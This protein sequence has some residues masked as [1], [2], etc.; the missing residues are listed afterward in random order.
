MDYLL[1]AP[2]PQLTCISFYSGWLRINLSGD[3]VFCLWAGRNFTGISYLCCL[4]P[5]KEL[6][7]SSFCF[8]LGRKDWKSFYFTSLYLFDLFSQLAYVLFG[9]LGGPLLGL[10]TFGM[11]CP[12]GNKWVLRFFYEYHF[13]SLLQRACEKNLMH[14]KLKRR[15]STIE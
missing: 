4:C 8:V 10:F 13:F 7:A 9:I 1:T 5:N 14:V 6:T 3:G 12:W 15:K 2:S 11:L